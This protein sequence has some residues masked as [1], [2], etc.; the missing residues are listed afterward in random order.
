M[1]LMN[2]F[3]LGN[4][5]LASGRNESFKIECDALAEDDWTCLAYLLFQRLPAFGKVEGVPKGGLKLAEKMQIYCTRG[6]ETLLIVD[7]VY[8]TGGSLERFRDGREAIGAVIFSRTKVIDRG[9]S[10]LFVMQ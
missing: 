10:A 7:D 2:L 3:Q 5:V 8:T 9:I 6:C 4:F 1:N